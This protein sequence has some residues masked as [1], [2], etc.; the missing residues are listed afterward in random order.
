MNEGWKWKALC[1]KMPYS[2]AWAEF[3]LQQDSNVTSWFKVK[4]GGGGDVCVCVG[5][6]G[7][8]GGGTKYLYI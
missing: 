2:H 6:G 7:E 3:H 5:G 1:N 4:G 8:G